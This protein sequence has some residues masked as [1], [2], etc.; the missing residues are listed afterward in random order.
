MLPEFS[1]GS[2]IHSDATNKAAT[3]AFEVDSR[4]KRSIPGGP[5]TSCPSLTTWAEKGALEDKEKASGRPL[6]PVDTTGATQSSSLDWSSQGAHSQQQDF[7]SLRPDSIL[8]QK[9]SE[10]ARDYNQAQDVPSPP[11]I[12]VYVML[13]LDTVG[14]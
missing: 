2:G 14:W 5:E 8:W 6:R 3:R 9:L 1:P 13:P 10:N 12:P 11:K 4:A 7:C